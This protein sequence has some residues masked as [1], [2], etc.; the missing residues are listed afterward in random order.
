MLLRLLLVPLL[1]L[2][3]LLLLAA[4]VATSGLTSQMPMG[5]MGAPWIQIRPRAQSLRGETLPENLMLGRKALP[6]AQGQAISQRTHP[7]K[8]DIF[9]YSDSDRFG[10]NKWSQLRFYGGSEPP[11]VIR[12]EILHRIPLQMSKVVPSRPI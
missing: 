6:R 9:K 3:P 5:P 2:P 7:R 1:L 12:S 8:C 10:S 11:C 4:Q